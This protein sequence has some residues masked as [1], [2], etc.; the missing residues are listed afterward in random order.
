MPIIINT[1]LLE[2]ET[3]HSSLPGV[4]AEATVR[5]LDGNHSLLNT[6]VAQNEATEGT[7]LC[8]SVN[9]QCT[10]SPAQLTH[11]QSSHLAPDIIFFTKALKHNMAEN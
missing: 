9:Y 11:S 6:E 4:T 2:K 1:R 7:W 8:I 3:L 10:H 5:H